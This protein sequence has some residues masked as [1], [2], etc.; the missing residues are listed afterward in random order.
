[1]DGEDENMPRT[2]TWCLNGNSKQPLMWDSQL[3]TMDEVRAR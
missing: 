3:M 2:W 1:M